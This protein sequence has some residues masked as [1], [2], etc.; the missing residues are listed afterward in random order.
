[1]IEVL[2]DGLLSRRSVLLAGLRA[3]E[4]V[5]TVLERLGAT[6]T[7]FDPELDEAGEGGAGWV[8]A[9]GTVDALVFDGRRTAGA[10]GDI[11]APGDTLDAA[12][13]VTA[14]VANGAFIPA[15]AGR[16]VLI[17]PPSPVAAAGLENLA[18]TLS[19]EWARYGITVTAIT[20]AADTPAE[21][22]ATLVAFLLSKAG[23]YYS[24]ARFDLAAIHAQSSPSTRSRSGS[25]KISW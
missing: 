6:V 4:S 20:P 3:G 14:A 17:A 16:I 7:S 8:R 15:A 2:R 22:V 23:G 25:L 13:I 11:A 5:G 18:R 10:P 12:W 21:T 19:I 24:G 1:M 9:H